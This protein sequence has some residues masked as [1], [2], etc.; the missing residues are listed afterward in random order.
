MLKHITLIIVRLEENKYI[1][2]SVI[3]EL[4]LHMCKPI[5]HEEYVARAPMC[6]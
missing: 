1:P 5:S 4:Q 6:V 3:S 2:V